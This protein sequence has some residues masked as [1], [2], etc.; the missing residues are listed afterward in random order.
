MTNDFITVEI[1]VAPFDF[2]RFV[3]AMHETQ[4]YHDAKTN[5]QIGSLF[6]DVLTGD[7]FIFMKDGGAWKIDKDQFAKVF[8]AILLQDTGDVEIRQSDLD[9]DEDD[10][11]TLYCDFMA[12]KL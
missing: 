10:P 4:T 7:N 11:D 1:Q 8:H 3:G 2:K 6:T 9:G 5:K 12:N